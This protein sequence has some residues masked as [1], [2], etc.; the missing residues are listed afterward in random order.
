[1]CPELLPAVGLENQLQ[2]FP[3]V[4]PGFGQRSPLRIHAWNLFHIGNV[5]AATL[6]NYCREF[7][8]HVNP[9]FSF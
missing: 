6:R 2:G 7:P 3:Q 5:P 8:L 9:L 4:A 1:L